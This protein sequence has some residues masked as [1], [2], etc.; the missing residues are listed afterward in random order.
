MVYQEKQLSHN[1]DQNKMPQSKNKKTTKQQKQG[2]D[3]KTTL[4]SK[5]VCNFGRIS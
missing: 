2:D 1:N 3:Y 5:N 4:K